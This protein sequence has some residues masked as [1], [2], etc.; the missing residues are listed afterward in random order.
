MTSRAS[1]S[2]NCSHMPWPDRKSTRLNSSHLVISYAVF[3][4][5]KKKKC[6]G[7]AAGVPA[8]R[9]AGVFLLHGVGHRRR[10]YGAREPRG[11]FRGTASAVEAGS[12]TLGQTDG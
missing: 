6:V 7:H 9:A 11:V 12:V 3:C 4:L 5:K 2:M 10:G 1:G 8:E